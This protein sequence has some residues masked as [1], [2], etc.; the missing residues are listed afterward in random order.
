MCHIEVEKE[1]AFVKTNSPVCI[2]VKY[3]IMASLVPIVVPEHNIGLLEIGSFE[4]VSY[5]SNEIDLLSNVKQKGLI[6]KFC[7]SFV[8]SSNVPKSNILAFSY[9]PFY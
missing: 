6:L 9:R 5:I 4:K 7:S 1:K 8:N 2:S 3:C